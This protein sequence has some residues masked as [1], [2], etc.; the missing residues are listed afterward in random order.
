MKLLSIDVGIKN[1]S[2]C[3]FE[4]TN[5][6]FFQIIQ[7]ENINLIEEVELKCN[8]CCKLAKFTKNGIPFCKKHTSNV[9]KIANLNKQTKQTLIDIANKYNINLVSLTNK[10]AII[11]S[12]NEY[13]KQNSYI[14]IVKK[15]ATKVDLVTIGRNIQQKFDDILDIHLNTI[16]TIIIENQI[17]PI[18]NK[19]KTIQGMISQYFIMKNENINIEFVSASNK[20]KDFIDKDKTEYKQRKKLG[21][22]ICENFIKNE[23][24]FQNWETFLDNHKKKD[25]LADCFLQGFWFIKHKVKLN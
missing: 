25:D 11:K 12:I 14:P 20:L 15:N 7:W 8:N 23:I 18:A 22:Q 9:E 3:L 24:M 13:F 5:T 6:E 1:L 16:H 21:T 19:M 2:F 4:L 17:G 10:S